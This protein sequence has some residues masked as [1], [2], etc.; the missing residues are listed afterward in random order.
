MP[1]SKFKRQLIASASIRNNDR[2]LDLGCGTATLT[3][4]LKSICPDAIVIGTDGDGKILEIGRR[5]TIKAGLEITFVQGMAFNLPYSDA[6]FD[7]VLSSLMF[8]HLTR[9]NKIRTLKEVNRVL[10]PGGGIHIADFGKP[11]NLL[12]RAAAYPWQLFDGST[13]TAD[14]V[15]GQLP[16]MIRDSG[17][18]GVREQPLT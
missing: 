4:L 3:L 12:M 8:H 5:K 7:G 13:T 14:N 6:S 15:S 10:R 2:I 11:Q 9:N 17:F 18:V 16:R 1:E